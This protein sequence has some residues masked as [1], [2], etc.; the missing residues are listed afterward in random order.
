MIIKDIAETGIICTYDF[1]K[2]GP[3]IVLRAEL[4]ALPIREKNVFDYKSKNNGI[5]HSC[6]HDGH[7]AILLGMAQY[8]S[9]KPV[10]ITGKIVLLFQPSEEIAMGAKKIMEDRRF[11]DLR[12]THI[13]GLHNIPQYPLG[14]I[15]LKRDVF[16]SASQGLI[17]RFHGVSSHAGNPE[18]GVSPL[19]AMLNCIRL[20]QET[21]VRYS[22]KDADTFI[23]IIHMKL[24]ERAFGTNPGEGVLMATFR[25]YNQHRMD[26]MANE[27]LNQLHHLLNSIKLDWNYEWVEVFPSLVNNQ[28]CFEIIEKTVKELNGNKI[29]I[30]KP[31]SWSEDFSYYLSQYHGALFG[32]GAGR[33]HHVLHHPSYDF[34]DELIEY[35]IGIFKGIIFETQKQYH[36]D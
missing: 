20:L 21:S 9:K 6:G 13:F 24:G 4:D 31:F 34:P 16:A 33:N 29:E 32:I 10:D 35:G 30:K 27:T 22:E 8:L 1:H 28:E 12:P 18:Q 5:S 36:G 15:I 11:H 14:S 23:T 2:P 3:C 17:I 25:S 19:L 7:M 26:E